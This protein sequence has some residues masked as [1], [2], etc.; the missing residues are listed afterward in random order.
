[1]TPIVICAYHEGANSIY[2]SFMERYHGVFLPV[3]GGA[4]AY[5]GGKP[6]YD[7]MMKDNDGENISE[8]NAYINEITQI[9]WAYKNYRR[10]GNPDMIG[11]CH[12]RRI[13]LLDYN[14]LDIN[15]IYTNRCVS[16]HSGGVTPWWPDTTTGTFANFCSEEL[17]EFYVDMF[18]YYLPDYIID[19]DI[20]FDERM[21]YA[22]NMFIMNRA[23]FFDYMSY[24]VR[25]LRF[26]FDENVFKEACSI[27]QPE[28]HIRRQMLEKSR[29]RGFLME[30]F[31]SVW[32]ERQQRLHHNVVDAQLAEFK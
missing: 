14:N 5:K 11:L 1:M 31:S 13:F 15:T 28:S 26:L 27:F 12:Y 10:I 32:F 23:S 2:A 29:C 17:V 21:Y 7:K 3:L 25:V 30:M 6:E 20:T 9:Y 18:R 22:R 4:Y 16:A 8:L 24:I 19:A